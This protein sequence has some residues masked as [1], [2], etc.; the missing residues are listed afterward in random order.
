MS[1]P[2]AFP[3]ALDS[4]FPPA[5]GEEG[6]GAI[7]FDLAAGIYSI[8][9]V[10]AA[11]T[12]PCMRVRRSSDNGE[13]DVFWTGGLVD[14]AAIMAHVGAGDG[15]V[16]TWYDQSGK[17]NHAA[18]TTAGNQP[19]IVVSGVMQMMAGRPT[20]SFTNATAQRLNFANL[21]V[22]R[23]VG[24]GCINATFMR[25]DA[26]TGQRQI[27][28]FSVGTGA[29]PFRL[30]LATF[31]QADGGLRATARRLD[32]DSATAANTNAVIDSLAITGTTAARYASGFATLWAKGGRFLEA[33]PSAGTTSNT[34]SQQAT[35]GGLASAN[36]FT[37]MISEVI[38]FNTEVDAA[39]LNAVTSAFWRT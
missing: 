13:I 22:F 28:A 15:F 36:Y 39:R 31:A 26:G 16:T 25:Q 5:V 11:Y 1:F 4:A 37:G 7:S 35:I 24:F 23:N 14:S 32:A 12:G 18:Q 9:R 19:T 17:A 34:A 33:L 10:R 29:T 38:L 6:A 20:L 3:P 30:G 21:D 8:R 2:T 27:A